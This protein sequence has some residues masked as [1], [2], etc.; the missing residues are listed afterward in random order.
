MNKCF[1]VS[2]GFFNTVQIKYVDLRLQQKEITEH[3][4]FFQNV[5]LNFN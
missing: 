2:V 3:K 4:N 5:K 1:T